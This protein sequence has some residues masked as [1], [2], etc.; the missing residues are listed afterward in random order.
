[1]MIL[2]T[3]YDEVGVVPFDSIRWAYEE[4][5]KEKDPH[6]YDYA[7][8]Y[9]NQDSPD[10]IDFYSEEPKINTAPRRIWERDK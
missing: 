3:R 9:G 2:L 6:E 7:V 4:H 10:R 5:L 1:M 8:L